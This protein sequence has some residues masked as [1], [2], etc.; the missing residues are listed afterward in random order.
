MGYAVVNF[1]VASSCSFR[2]NREK[3]FPDAGVD[4]GAG[5]IKA[6]CSRPEVADV[7]FPVS[8]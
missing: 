3:I 5:D 2:D 1:R 7:L 4:G 8:M 6:S